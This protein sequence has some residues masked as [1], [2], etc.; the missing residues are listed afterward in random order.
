MFQNYNKGENMYFINRWISF[1]C[2]YNYSR[3]KM[4]QKNKIKSYTNFVSCISSILLHSC[5]TKQN[6]DKKRKIKDNVLLV[7]SQTW[8]SVANAHIIT[9]YIKR[10][11]SLASVLIKK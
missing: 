8:H 10:G 2:L 3:I 9:E 1:H 7:Y 4:I 11:Q 6:K 5:K